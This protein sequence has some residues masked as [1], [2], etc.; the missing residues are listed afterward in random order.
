L[1][2]LFFNYIIETFSGKKALQYIS[3][4][5]TVILIALPARFMFANHPN[6]YIYFNELKGGIKGAYGNYETDYYFNSLKEGFNWLKENKLKDFKPTAGHD[7]VIVA[8]NIPEMMKQYISISGLPV[9]FA[10]VRYYQRGESDWDYGIFVSRFLDKEQ[11]INGYFPG[12]KPLHIVEAEGVPLSTIQANDR[13]RN[14]LKGQEASKAQ[15]Y[16]LAVQYYEKAVALDPKDAEAW[17][18]LAVAAFQSG[19]KAKS[20]DAI[21]KAYAISCMDIGNANT[22]GMIYLQAQDF[23]KALQVF[24]KITEENPDMPEG[25]MGLGQAQAMLKNY[26]A[27]IDDINKAVALNPQYTA[28][29]YM[30]LAGIYQQMGDMAMAQKYANAAQQAGSGR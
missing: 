27:A 24:S 16:A 2:A 29:G 22:A 18:N 6:E 3:I 30:M 13:E 17:R 21:G 15:N 11:L 7:S 25:W 20:M 5:I 19:D 14:A 26:S 9:K 12:S 8:S 28:Q 4:G 10:Y 23:N 1:G